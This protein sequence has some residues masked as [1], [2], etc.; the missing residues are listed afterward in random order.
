[1][2]LNK[3]QAGAAAAR[4]STSTVG[5]NFLKSGNTYGIGKCLMSLFV[6]QERY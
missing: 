5:K 4:A 2:S 1:M 6:D 3:S